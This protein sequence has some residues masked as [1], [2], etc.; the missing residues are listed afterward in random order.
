MGEDLVRPSGEDRVSVSNEDRVR[1]S[2]GALVS[3]S[4]EGPVSPAS[5]APVDPKE[6][7]LLI[8]RRWKY[9]W[10]SQEDSYPERARR[11]DANM[12]HDLARRL[13]DEEF[14]PTSITKTKENENGEDRSGRPEENVPGTP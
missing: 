13:A 3:A 10:M 11:V 9:Y 6:K 1:P 8:V 12:V 7:Y 4:S 14:G 5:G 2:M